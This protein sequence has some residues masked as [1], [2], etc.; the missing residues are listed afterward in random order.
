M[1]KTIL[2]LVAAAACSSGAVAQTTFKWGP[3]AG[4]NITNN[5]V[6]VKGAEGDFYDLKPGLKAGVAADYGFREH[7]SL[8][9]GLY[10]SQKGAKM[11]SK[12]SSTF[13]YLELPL[14]FTYKTG[15]E[16]K[17]R[18]FAGIG[19]YAALG[20]G[21]RFKQPGKDATVTFGTG[22]KADFQLMDF[23]GSI[24]LGYELPIG[25]FIRGQYSQG[26]YN[27]SRSNSVL[28][29]NFCFGLSVG[30]YFGNNR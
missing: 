8:Q 19:P 5:W 7:L 14:H 11:S 1:K 28:Y 10:F 3:E 17:G 30:Y 18:F 4:L 29:R 21:G 2:T 9:A 23:G 13:N 27:I 20:L 22:K 25:L 16:G 26:I 6:D 15:Q 12:T 24:S